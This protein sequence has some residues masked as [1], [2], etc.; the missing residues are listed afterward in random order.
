MAEAP[1]YKLRAVQAGEVRAEDDLFGR[2]LQG[3]LNGVVLKGVLSAEV[4]GG[5]VRRLEAGEMTVAR[6]RFAREF[7]AYSI[8]PCLDQAEHGLEPYFGGVEEI[9]RAFDALFG[10]DVRAQIEGVVR[11]VAGARPLVWPKNEAGRPYGKMTLRCLPP[12]GLIPPHCE[13]EQLPRAPYDGL[14]AHID[15][16]A[17]VSFYLTLAA[18][19]DGG[20]LSIHDMGAHELGRLPVRDGHSDVGAALL[21]RGRVLVRPMAGDMIV[22]DGGRFF[23]Q[24]RPVGGARNRWTMGGFMALSASGREVLAWA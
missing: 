14:R 10:A 19:E 17:L 21:E 24:V 18:A 16:T 23:H 4:A 15:T 12:G 5:L 7:E 2:I 13:N 3:E 20:E 1:F 9:E 22:F 6:R 11:R 8:G